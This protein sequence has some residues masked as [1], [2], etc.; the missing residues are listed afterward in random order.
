VPEHPRWLSRVPR[1]LA[2]LA[3]ALRAIGRGA[4][5]A[6]SYANYL[7]HFATHHPGQQPQSRE[8]FFRADQAS[9]WEGVRR[10]C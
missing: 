7:R 2:R 5:G 1:G 9:R 10:C 6:D 4:T 3:G 8:A